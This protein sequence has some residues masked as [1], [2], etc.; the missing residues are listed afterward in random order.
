MSSHENDP[1]LDDQLRDIPVPP[2]LLA[3]LRRIAGGPADRDRQ[4]VPA[5]Q[6]SD[7]RVDAAMREVEV[8]TDLLQRLKAIP[9]NQPL[10]LIETSL[11]QVSLPSTLLSKLVDLPQKI[12]REQWIHV[13]IA[14]CLLLAVSIGVI[15]LFSQWNDPSH[16]QITTGEYNEEGINESATPRE[17]PTLPEDSAMVSTEVESR[18]DKKQLDSETDPPSAPP[19]QAIASTDA[20]SEVP[21]R[22]PAVERLNNPFLDRWQ[23]QTAPRQASDDMAELKMPVIDLRGG[24]PV[25]VSPSFNRNFL[26][27]HRTYPIVFPERDIRLADI[28]VPLNHETMSFDTVRSLIAQRDSLGLEKSV[29]RT[30]DFLAAIPYGFAPATQD[31]VELRISLGP[32]QFGRTIPRAILNEF[33]LED[34]PASLLQVGLKAGGQTKRR[35]AATHLTLVI[36]V[37]GSMR[38]SS[39]MVKVC[40]AVSQLCEQLGDDDRVTLV[41]FSNTSYSPLRSVAPADVGKIREVLAAVKPNGPSNV[42]KGVQMG[43]ALAH[44]KDNAA[45]LKQHMVVLTDNANIASN[46]RS[47]ETLLE[48]V[49]FAAENDILVSG[50]ELSDED[51]EDSLLS[52]VSSEGKG[53]FLQS[54]DQRKLYA[55]LLESLTGSSAIVARDV[56]LRMK[57]SP[58]SVLGY[59]LIGHE[60]DGAGVM[61]DPVI[62]TDLYA[63]EELCSLFEIWPT[64]RPIWEL[65][66]VDLHWKDPLTGQEYNTKTDIDWWEAS[67]S[68][69]E[70]SN[71][72]KRAAIAAEFAEALRSSPFCRVTGRDHLAHISELLDSNAS[73]LGSVSG[74]DTLREMLTTLEAMRRSP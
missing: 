51:V 66:H 33:R 45:N 10:D 3:Q 65:A 36:D 64:E 37:S 52:K 39:R 59:R 63:G 21:M 5:R 14:A 4:I 70:S 9:A 50:F 32:S 23:V 43:L 1:K 71:S 31:A 55:F 47:T 73:E 72:L 12:R 15:T 67:P 60:P 58:R 13:S 56:T 30:E 54:L 19:R 16:S 34:A 68:F 24:A 40:R 11:K 53:D 57:Y 18:D 26:F 20:S 42:A 17:G 29:I 41:L 74:L 44:T 22:A 27:E 7:T 8:P 69:E 6:W 2:E 61:V 62:T 35:F 38:W 28:Q 46:N 25:P 48:M 49:S